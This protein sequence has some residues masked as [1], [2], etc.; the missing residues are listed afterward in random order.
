MKY[1][2]IAF[3]FSSCA[4]SQISKIEDTHTTHEGHKLYNIYFKDGKM[5]EYMYAKEVSYGLK[6]GVWK[7]NEDL[8][9]NP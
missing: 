3:L 8:Q 6:T 5:M 7:Y 2:I 1:L 9:F 4:V